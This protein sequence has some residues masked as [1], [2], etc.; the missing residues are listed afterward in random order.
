MRRLPSVFRYRP[1]PDGHRGQR[2]NDRFRRPLGRDRT[3]IA[4][5]AIPTAQGTWSVPPRPLPS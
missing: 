5:F 4:M 2:P 3:R 1:A